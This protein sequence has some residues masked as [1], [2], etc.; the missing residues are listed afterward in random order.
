VAS[1]RSGVRTRIVPR[2][3]GALNGGLLTSMALSA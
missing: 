3:A 1:L 2:F